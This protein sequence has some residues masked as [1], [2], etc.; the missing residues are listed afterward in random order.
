MP[1][2]EESH[3]IEGQNISRGPSN[4]DPCGK[5]PEMA[6]A[7]LAKGELLD[8]VSAL[9][10][11][12]S[13]RVILDQPAYRTTQGGYSGE[14]SEDK[15]FLF[16]TVGRPSSLLGRGAIRLSGAKYRPDDDPD[17]PLPVAHIPVDV[18]LGAGDWGDSAADRNGMASAIVRGYCV[19]PDRVFAEIY[20]AIR[21]GRIAAGM[22]SDV[23]SK[24]AEPKTADD[25]GPDGEADQVEYLVT[26]YFDE[27]MSVTSHGVDG[28]TDL[29]TA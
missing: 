29:C 19:D 25:E 1:A 20:T 28:L 21:D 9:G 12:A 16:A 3:A 10:V 13:G 7:S 22:I 24:L 18:G 23:R 26:M 4:W 15:D 27:G 11:D 17:S 8:W 5:L 6:A 2:K 14:P